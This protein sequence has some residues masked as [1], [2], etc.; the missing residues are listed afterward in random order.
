MADDA[1]RAQK[2]IEQERQAGVLLVA[3]RLATPGRD[4]CEDCGDD[5]E[6]AR[7]KAIPSARKCHMCQ[8]AAERIAR[9]FTGAQHRSDR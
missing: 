6:P 7:R 1:D 2:R 9:L 4:D 8:E 3:D 5:I